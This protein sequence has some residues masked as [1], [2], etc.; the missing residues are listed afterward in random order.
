MDHS[1]GRDVV[2]SL[3][4]ATLPSVGHMVGVGFILR[5]FERDFVAKLILLFLLYSLLPIGEIFLILYLGGRLGNYLTLAVA[6]STGLV[7]VLMSLVRLRET[8]RRL[9][10]KIRAGEYPV[11]EFVELAGVLCSAVLLLTPGFGTDL[12]GL[13][14]FVPPVRGAVGRALT[15]RFDRHLKEVYEYLRLYEL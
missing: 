9:R 12:L 14:L 4:L 8:N 13:L 10:A 11:G 1:G 5:F 2:A 6:A 15:R 7:G 3:R